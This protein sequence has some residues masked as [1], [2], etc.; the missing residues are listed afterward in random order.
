MLLAVPLKGQHNWWEDKKI[1]NVFKNKNGRLL[2]LF[3]FLHY[4]KILKIHTALDKKEPNL[5]SI[6][7]LK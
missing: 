6:F 2:Y 3:F 4:L 5:A 1:R 7:L